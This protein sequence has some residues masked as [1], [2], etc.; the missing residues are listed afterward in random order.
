MSL[1]GNI[2]YLTKQ[3]WVEI[4]NAYRETAGSS[5]LITAKELPDLIRSLTGTSI[6]IDSLSVTENGIYTAPEGHAYTPVS[7][8]VPQPEIWDGSGIIIKTIPDLIAGIWLINTPFNFLVET[9]ML[10]FSVEGVFRTLDTSGIVTL[11][12]PLEITFEDEKLKLSNENVYNLYYEN[13]Q[14]KSVFNE[15]E[16]IIDPLSDNG[17]IIRILEIQTFYNKNDPIH[18]QLANWLKTNAIQI[19]GQYIEN[20]NEE[21]TTVIIESFEQES[22]NCGT[23]VI[24]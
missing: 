10:G 4:L 22:N 17:V 21:G 2:A 24:L 1:V 7:V 9:E 18:V 8:S 11:I 13:G 20:I 14:I 19:T 23:T 16:N 3:Q 15:E 5:Q 12:S 6:I